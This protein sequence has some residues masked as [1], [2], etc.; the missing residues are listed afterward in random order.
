[1]D[2][3]QNIADLLRQTVQSTPMAGGEYRCYNFN[4]PGLENYILRVSK[5]LTFLDRLNQR[6]SSSTSLN[7]IRPLIS[8]IHVGQ[9]LMQLGDNQDVTIVL[10]QSGQSLLDIAHAPATISESSDPRVRL[11]D[12]VLALQKNGANPFVS[13]F[14]QA[15]RL[16][17]S[18]FTADFDIANIFLDADK[19]TLALIDQNNRRKLG[20]PAVRD[21]H[22]FDDEIWQLTRH[23]DPSTEQNDAN[24]Y[25][26]N[27]RV[28]YLAL[29]KAAASQVLGHPP[30]PAS[31]AFANVS[32]VQAIGI[33]DP[34]GVRLLVDALKNLEQRANIPGRS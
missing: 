9:P 27:A 10:R 34:N 3:P 30:Q 28:A 4:V 33:T 13:L 12:K 16:G 7:P 8:G 15:Y 21:A 19:G 11:L 25:Y 20:S 2:E 29:V 1:M 26:E 5:G 32:D 18:G 22:Y 17:K 31:V 23:F 14:E 6:L 24:A